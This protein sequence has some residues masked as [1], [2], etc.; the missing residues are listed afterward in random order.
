MATVD[1]AAVMTEMLHL[2][3]E[4]HDRLNKRDVEMEPRHQRRI[5]LLRLVAMVA[6]NYRPQSVIT[7]VE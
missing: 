2:M 7:L 5:T 3:R 1:S 6:R 4:E